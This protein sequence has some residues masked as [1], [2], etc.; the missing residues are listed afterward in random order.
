M[1]LIDRSSRQ[2]WLTVFNEA[3]KQRMYLSPRR[4]FASLGLSVNKICESRGAATNNLSSLI[5]SLA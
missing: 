1:L 2:M 3:A 5:S 4:G